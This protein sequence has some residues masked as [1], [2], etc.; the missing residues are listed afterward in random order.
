MKNAWWKAR[1]R[2]RKGRNFTP[3]ERETLSR[4]VRRHTNCVDTIATFVSGNDWPPI[5]RE[6]L[7]NV[8]AIWEMTKITAT[9]WTFIF[10]KNYCIE[11][12]LHLRLSPPSYG[13]SNSIYIS[14]TA[15]QQTLEDS[16]SAVSTSI[17]PNE[18][19]LQSSWLVRTRLNI[20]YLTELNMYWICFQSIFIPGTRLNWMELNMD[21]KYLIARAKRGRVVEN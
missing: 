7:T 15:F 21:E 4:R 3:Y 20:G 14:L 12:D 17:F 10:L 9:N 19:S 2:K 8:N 11:L 5:N 1:C 16:F 6:F 18:D 13:W